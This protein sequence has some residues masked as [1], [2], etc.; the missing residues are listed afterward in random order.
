VTYYPPALLPPEREEV[1]ASALDA[2]EIGVPPVV[3]PTVTV[4]V[5]VVQLLDGRLHRE[6]ARAELSGGLAAGA[7]DQRRR[8]A[9]DLSR[10]GARMMT[11]LWA[12]GQQT[13]ARAW[14]RRFELV[15]AAA[16][17]ARAAS[18]GVWGRFAVELA[19][20][21]AALALVTRLPRPA[22]G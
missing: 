7:A 9:Q 4:W 15:G 19:G 6:P 10:Y 17:R 12:G 21:E 14:T 5:R 8:L 1:V 11:T 22:E 2:A 20:G 13:R 3:A 18:H 16:D